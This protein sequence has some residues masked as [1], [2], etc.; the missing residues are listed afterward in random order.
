MKQT[1][2]S[3]SSVEARRNSNANDEGGFSLVEVVFAMIILLIV[4]LG[5][6]I[7]FAYAVNYNAGNSARAQALTILQKEVEL[8]LI[9]LTLHYF[10]L[11][12]SIY[13]F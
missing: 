2:N 7:T 1:I 6:F 3:N 13:R 5:V 10:A 9:S 4:L 12:L 8:M 11:C